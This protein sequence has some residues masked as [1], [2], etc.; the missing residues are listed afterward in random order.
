[1]PDDPGRWFVAAFSTVGGGDP[2]D[3]LADALVEW[4]DA[5]MATF[6]WRRG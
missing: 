2:R 6:R 5:V 3:D 1:M 4:F